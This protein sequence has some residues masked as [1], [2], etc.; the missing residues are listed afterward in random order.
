M[1]VTPQSVIHIGLHDKELEEIVLAWVHEA[2]MQYPQM[3]NLGENPGWRTK[4][5]PIT[6]KIY[7]TMS[8]IDLFLHAYRLFR[9]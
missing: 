5:K 1:L 7:V 8:E 6:A 9:S 2:M 4:I 3:F